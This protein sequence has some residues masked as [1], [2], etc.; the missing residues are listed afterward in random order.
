MLMEEYIRPLGLNIT[1]FA[2]QIGISRIAVSEIVNGRR[3]ISPIMAMRLAHALGTTEQ[4]WINLQTSTDLFAARQ[5]PEA[6]EILKLP[7]L[8]RN[9]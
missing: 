3:G 6:R 1:A 7:V 5:T 9:P 8:Q 2:H 4:Y